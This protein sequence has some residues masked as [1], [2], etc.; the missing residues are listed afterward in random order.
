MPRIV[1][2][3]DSFKGTVSA[4]DAAAA[5]ARGW[6]R[7][8]PD[9]E[10]V[11]RPMADGGEGTLDAFAAAVDGAARI[12]ITVLGPDDRPVDTSWLRL[13][14]TGGEGDT[15]VVELA[16]TSGITLLD[17][18]R[19][20]DAH[21]LGFGQA[22]AAALDAGVEGLLL[23]IGGSSSTDGGVGALTALGARFLDA[24]SRP[25]PLGNRGL[26]VLSQA[27][28]SGLRMVP[29]G[30]AQILSDVTSPLLGES[31]AAAVFGPQKGASPDL[32]DV[33]ESNLARLARLVPVHESVPGSGAAGGTGFGLLAWGATMTGG[34]SAVADAIGLDDTLA[35]AD[36]VVTGEG[37]FDGQ[38]AAGKAPTEVARRAAAAGAPV[39]LVAG[40]ITAETDRFA[41]SVSLTD[42]AGDGAAAM[43]EPVRWL[44]RAGA[45]LA[46]S[47]G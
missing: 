42:L 3:P 43:A 1:I 26:G 12:P 25:I 35:G 46:R 22:I 11:L 10:L 15:A 40:A 44:E 33:L 41:A 28:L 30:G 4:A 5:I 7:V 36:L 32:I 18:L 24:A 21:T 6:A 2:A 34:A 23:A 29:A 8:A 39:A 45:E 47:A 16:M 31:G 19:P 37:R 20:L 13:P 9:D 38:S 17:T 14:G 27:D